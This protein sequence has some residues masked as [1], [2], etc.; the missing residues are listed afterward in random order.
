MAQ[1]VL[2]LL[3]IG[4]TMEYGIVISTGVQT[5]NALL[6]GYSVVPLHWSGAI[7]KDDE[8]LSF[9]GTIQ[10]IEAKI[11]ESNPGFS[12]KMSFEQRAGNREV[13]NIQDRD[14][15]GNIVCDV[16]S[17]GRA[18]TLSI[19]VG[20]MALKYAAGTCGI[21]PGPR[22]CTQISCAYDGGIWLCNDNAWGIDLS[23]NDIAA[24]VD[25]I[26]DQCGTD[27]GHGDVQGQEFDTENYNVIVGHAVCT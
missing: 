2:Y 1:Y 23:C 25:N 21:G 7:E 20:S 17:D 10:E 18:S 15:N 16:G 26:I 14:Q 3:I 13:S 9:N 8:I 22:V 5:H 12:W 19:G 6:D 27:Q 11:Q 24:Y 4:L